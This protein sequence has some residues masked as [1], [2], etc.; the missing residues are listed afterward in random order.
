M[1]VR[2]QSRAR[3]GHLYARGRDALRTSARTVTQPVGRS[4][5]PDPAGA[6]VI[7]VRRTAIVRARSAWAVECAYGLGWMQTRSRLGRYQ[8]FD[9]GVARPGNRRR[10]YALRRNLQDR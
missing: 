9:V 6:N 10:S 8:N 7:A 5:V 4:H 3:V 1:R 2:M